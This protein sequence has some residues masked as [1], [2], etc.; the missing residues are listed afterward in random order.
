MIC[1]CE[2]MNRTKDRKGGRGAQWHYT[3]S[4]SDICDVLRALTLKCQDDMPRVILAYF[5]CHPIPSVFSGG[6]SAL[7]PASWQPVFGFHRLY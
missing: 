5:L 3:E 7:F 2:I 4:V 6:F 1:F